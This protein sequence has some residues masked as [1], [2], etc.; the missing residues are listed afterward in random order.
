MARWSEYLRHFQTVWVKSW[1]KVGLTFTGSESCVCLR[2]VNHDLPLFL[3]LL[4]PFWWWLMVMM[5]KTA[6]MQ[7][8]WSSVVLCNLI[9]V[10][11]VCIF[12]LFYVMSGTTPRRR[13]NFSNMRFY[14]RLSCMIRIIK[15][16]TSSTCYWLFS[17]EQAKCNCT[18]NATLLQRIHNVQEGSISQFVVY[19]LLMLVLSF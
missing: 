9:F 4:L 11:Q 18:S 1:E 7:I 8:S 5:T 14:R 12:G 3:L 10:V 2:R 19:G 16:V 15:S 6:M 13:R 17:W